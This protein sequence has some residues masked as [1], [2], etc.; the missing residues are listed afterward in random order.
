MLN[1]T[2]MNTRPDE[3]AI[4]LAAHIIAGC[5][6]EHPADAVLRAQLRQAR[7]LSRSAA[8]EV[9]RGVFAWFRW[10]GWLEPGHP[11]EEGVRRALE[12]AENYAREPRSFSGADLLTRAVPAWIAGVCEVTEGW[13]RELQREPAL[14]LRARAG[15]GGQLAAHL[16]GAQ[17]GSLPDSLRYDGTE[18]LFRHA[19]FH[20]GEF[21]IQDIAS[22]AVGWVCA[23]QPGETWWDAC[24]GEGGKLLHLSQ[25]ME[26]RGLI[27][28]SDRARWRLDKLRRRAARARC[29][30]YR[31]ALWDGGPGLPTRTRF[32]GVL[33]DAPCA[34]LGTWGRNPHA[35]W[36]TVPNDVEEL[37]AL[38]LRLLAACAPALQPGGRLVYA[39]CTL[40]R[41]ETVDVCEAFQARCP[42]FEPLPFSHPFRTDAAPSAQQCWWPQETGGNGMFVAQWRAGARSPGAGLK[43]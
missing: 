18:D 21:E 35:R 4:S 36:T 19:L 1:P 8:A 39:V 3:R 10:F 2:P 37:A 34:G 38:Q 43:S 41:P 27:W 9:A 31:A 12:L 22:Q 33:L 7:E 17:P 16:A 28:A 40:S 5:D 25:L 32:D 24:A 29:F 42:D 13:L 14:W 11:V 20:A 6:R 26:N 15:Q 23:P 30:N